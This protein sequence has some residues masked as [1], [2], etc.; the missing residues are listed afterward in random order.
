[1]WTVTRE[2]RLGGRVGMEWYPLSCHFGSRE[3]EG[4]C[5]NLTRLRHPRRVG[6]EPGD[7]LWPIVWGKA[8]GYSG[9]CRPGH[10]SSGVDSLWPAAASFLWLWRQ[11]DSRW[12]DRDGRCKGS[13]E[14][15]RIR[16]RWSRRD[17]CAWLISETFRSA[18][19][20]SAKGCRHVL[21]G[22]LGSY[23]D[24][25]DCASSRWTSQSTNYGRIWDGKA[26]L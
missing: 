23:V 4:T 10:L 14:L 25:L 6:N 3:R 9:Q 17:N 2:M 19:D 16:S 26:V 13:P 15:G 24:H 18:A 20:Q 22:W 1:M 21:R 7:T 12:T 11:S 5:W 8:R